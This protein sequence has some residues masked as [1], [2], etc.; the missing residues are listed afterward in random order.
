MHLAEEG[1]MRMECLLIAT[2]V[3]GNIK[4]IVW[5]EMGVFS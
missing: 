5:V 1:A 3:P 4:S 2:N